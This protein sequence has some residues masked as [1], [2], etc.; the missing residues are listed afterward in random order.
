MRACVNLND[1]T[2]SGRGRVGESGACFAQRN[3]PLNPGQKAEHHQLDLLP[4]P[5]GRVCAQYASLM[6]RGVAKA[7]MLPILTTPLSKAG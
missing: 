7:S 3:R 5:S 6:V 4:N 2:A 1:R